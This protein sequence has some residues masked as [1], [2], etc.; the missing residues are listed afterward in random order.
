MP[1]FDFKNWALKTS[2]LNLTF[3]TFTL[4]EFSCF[5]YFIFKTLHLN[6]IFLANSMSVDNCFTHHNSSSV[7]LNVFFKLKGKIIRDNLLLFLKRMAV[8]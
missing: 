6:L 2:S 1:Y 8:N 5:I 4:L 3:K 7:S